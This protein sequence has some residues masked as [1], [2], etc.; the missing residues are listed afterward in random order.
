MLDLLGARHGYGDTGLWLLLSCPP[1]VRDTV[2][3]GLLPGQG[4]GKEDRNS[5]GHAGLPWT[6]LSSQAAGSLFL[7]FPSF[8]SFFLNFIP[9]WA[10]WES[11]EGKSN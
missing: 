8:I 9:R 11:A 10:S 7:S 5:Q 6:E 2:L 1:A 4:S 3:S